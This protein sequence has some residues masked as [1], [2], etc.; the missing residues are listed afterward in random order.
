[1]FRFDPV[2][3]VVF[4]MMLDFI[5]EP[6]ESHGGGGANHTSKN[7]QAGRRAKHHPPKY[8]EQDDANNKCR[9]ARKVWHVDFFVFHFCVSLSVLFHDQLAPQHSHLTLEAIFTFFGRGE[10][11]RHLFAFG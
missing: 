3:L 1:M 7:H 8:G 10:F 4:S 2:S 6:E 9:D 5:P 11:Q